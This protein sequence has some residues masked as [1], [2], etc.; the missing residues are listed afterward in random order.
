MLLLSSLMHWSLYLLFRALPEPKKTGAKSTV[1]RKVSGAPST[2]GKPSI[3][4]MHAKSLT[5][6]GDAKVAAAPSQEGAS[7]KDLC[8]NDKRRLATLIKVRFAMG[9]TTVL[10]S[11]LQCCV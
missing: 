7:L 8:V 5:S 4:N 6:K 3:Q 9:L 11:V 1:S 10:N 2:S